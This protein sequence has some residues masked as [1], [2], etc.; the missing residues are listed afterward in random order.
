MYTPDNWRTECVLIKLIIKQVMEVKDF[1]SRCVGAVN[2]IKDT[3][4]PQFSEVHFD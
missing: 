2:Q 3:K 1:N 4:F